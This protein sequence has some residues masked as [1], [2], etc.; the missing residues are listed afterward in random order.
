MKLTEKP[1]QETSQQHRATDR[2]DP[3]NGAADGDLMEGSDT[4]EDSAI[5][6]RR[7]AICPTLVVDIAAHGWSPNYLTPALKRDPRA[8]AGPHNVRL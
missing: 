3:I 4:K 7:T 1:F 5:A 6:E 8:L 2:I